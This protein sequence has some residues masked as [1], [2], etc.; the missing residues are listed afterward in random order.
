MI[1]FI[2][3]IDLNDT[4][5]SCNYPDDTDQFDEEEQFTS[6]NLDSSC[7]S[8]EEVMRV[9][10][11]DVMRVSNYHGCDIFIESLAMLS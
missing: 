7:L 10:N 9:A 1:R 6:P 5:F 4:I 11:L 8:E 3:Q 2:L